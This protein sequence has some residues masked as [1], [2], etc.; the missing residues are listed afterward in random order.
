M[1]ATLSNTYHQLCDQELIRVVSDELQ[2]LPFVKWKNTNAA[3]YKMPIQLTKASSPSSKAESGFNT[4]IDIS[5]DLTV[6]TKDFTLTEHVTGLA[7]TDYARVLSG[8]PQEQIIELVKYR[9]FEKLDGDFLNVIMD[10]D[11]YTSTT[12]ASGDFVTFADLDD[13]I[14]MAGRKGREHFVIYATHEQVASLEAEGSIQSKVLYSDGTIGQIPVIEVENGYEL[15]LVLV[16]V[17][18][19]AVV[20]QEN[21]TIDDIPAMLA[22]RQFKGIWFYDFGMLSD[23]YNVAFVPKRELIIEDGTD[24][25]DTMFEAYQGFVGIVNW[26]KNNTT[27]DESETYGYPICYL[28]D[29]LFNQEIEEALR[30]SE[31][32][33]PYSNWMYLNSLMEPPVGDLSV[34]YMKDDDIFVFYV[35][36]PDGDCGDSYIE[37]LPP[38][39]FEF[40]AYYSE[41]MDLP[42]YWNDETG[43]IGEPIPL[44]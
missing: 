16:D 3:T 23:A 19:L 1:P 20:S 22:G 40:M 37:T 24:V 32:D 9:F 15:P 6:G 42:C 27:L 12:E 17:R 5:N 8:L 38:E 14:K 33:R 7:V 25:D 36:S 13:A 2:V 4:P 44:E 30:N 28:I 34:D 29:H 21:P 18:N 11:S 10:P 43:T 31:L 26:V 35:Y 39:E 41:D